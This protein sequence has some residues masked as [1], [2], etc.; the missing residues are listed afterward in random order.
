M[1]ELSVAQGILG[2]IEAERRKRRFD[3]VVGVH[4]RVGALSCID[5]EALGFAFEAAAEGTCADGAELRTETEERVLTCRACGE[6]VAADHPTP[7]CPAC[8]SAD[9]SL[10]GGMDME[11]VSLEVESDDEDPGE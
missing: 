7:A 3:R 2:V 11:I 5:P 10:A 6:R 8:G 9:L 4:L 1:H